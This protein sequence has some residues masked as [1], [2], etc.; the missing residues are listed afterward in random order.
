M[1]D[2]R[3]LGEGEFVSEVLRQ[4]EERFSRKHKLIAEGFD[5]DKVV[6]R[7]GGLLEMKKEEVVSSS[8]SRANVRA[9][10]MVCYWSNNELGLSQVYL[11]KM[12]GISQPAVCSAIRRGQEFVKR[13]GYTL[14]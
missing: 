10:D 14:S 3:I 6:S 4:N 8:K 5:F 13:R 12:F 11:A 9:R 7:V 2:E 1:A